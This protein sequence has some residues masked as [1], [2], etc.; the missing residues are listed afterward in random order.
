MAV[1]ASTVLK[2]LPMDLK[3]QQ[4]PGS[5]P[6]TVEE[7]GLNTALLRGNTRCESPTTYA[8][9][10]KD[11]NT[12]VYWISLTVEEFEGAKLT[13]DCSTVIPCFHGHGHMPMWDKMLFTTCPMEALTTMVYHLSEM[14]VATTEPT[15]WILV[16][17][18]AQHE[19]RLAKGVTDLFAR[20]YQHVQHQVQS[21]RV[22]RLTDYE[23]NHQVHQ[24]F[25]WQH[26][27]LWTYNIPVCFYDVDMSTERN[28]RLLLQVLEYSGTQILN[29]L[30]QAT[31]E[32]LN[33]ILQQ[34]HELQ[35]PAG[36]NTAHVRFQGAKTI[37]RLRGNPDM[38]QWVNSVV[39][40]VEIIA[41]INK[42]RADLLE[43]I[44]GE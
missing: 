42:Y 11:A 38:P 44:D 28:K 20:G 21:G 16:M 24:C 7:L 2:P 22:W 43:N 17:D 33:T 13:T 34:M 14:H 37:E 3:V 31:G 9:Q 35:N 8:S 5:I 18:V 27:Y 19:L 25:T 23:K 12:L 30:P 32:K 36:Y 39:N 26:G 10:M 15:T 4:V 1:S 40:P 6:K 41:E 29:N